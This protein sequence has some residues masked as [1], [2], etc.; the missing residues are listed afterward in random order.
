MR[1]NSVGEAATGTAQVGVDG[2]IVPGLASLTAGNLLGPGWL[3][4]DTLFFQ[5]QDGVAFRL[6]TYHLPSTTLTEVS[7]SGFNIG[8]AGNGLWAAFLTS[9]GVRT[10]AGWT[11]PAAYVQDVDATGRVVVL[12]NYQAGG[13]VQVYSAAGAL[14]RTYSVTEIYNLS[15]LRDDI[16]AYN[17]STGWFLANV[18]TGAG[19]SYAQRAGVNWV[20]PVDNG[21]TLWVVERT[22]DL[23]I[24]EPTS[25]Q[26]YQVLSALGMAN[27]GFN[28]DAMLISAGVLRLGFCRSVGEGADTLVVV[29]L[30][31]A[32]G[33]TQ[34]KE[35][36]GGFSAGPTL[37]PVTVT[38][39]AT[40]SGGG[41]NPVPVAGGS[42]SNIVRTIRRPSLPSSRPPKTYPHVAQIGIRNE[43]DPKAP[44][45]PD[46]RD[47]LAASQMTSRLLWDTTGRLNDLIAA[48]ETRLGTAEAAQARQQVAIESAAFDAKQAMA[49]AGKVTAQDLPQPTGPNLPPGQV[50]GPPQPAPPPTTA[51]PGT[52]DEIDI[53]QV[54]WQGL[55]V[56]NWPI[57]AALT[58][59]QITPTQICLDYTGKNTWPAVDPSADGVL[60]PGN[61]W[62]FA[63]IGGVWYGSTYEWLRVGQI[64]KNVTGPEFQDYVTG[65]APMDSWAPALGETVGF[66][67][68]S[69]ARQGPQSPVNQRTQIRLTT[70]PF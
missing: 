47:A 54:V 33:T 37:T 50:G 3:D 12:G 40:T 52:V 53:T 58:N 25:N 63:F 66:M 13:P 55:N 67:V 31:L 4:D 6:G 10:S 7:T 45:H 62:V 23:W 11:L 69:L 8:F 19:V 49:V 18:D 56:A 9:S 60:S 15:V 65:G 30:D 39:G 44:I 32:T 46:V 61:P 34:V 26:A 68:S 2:V 24:R 57:T 27:Q 28:P 36:S 21:G 5:Y 59:I 14:L 48:F 1:F 51:P 35:G 16:L 29:D 64:C 22:N 38:L 17:N 43:V 20:I 42:S 70:W 41:G